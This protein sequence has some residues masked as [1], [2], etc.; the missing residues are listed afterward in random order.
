MSFRHTKAV[1][2]AR[3]TNSGLKLVALALAD[4]ANEAGECWPSRGHL[5]KL[6][7]LEPRSVQRHIQTLRRKGFLTIVERFVENRQRSNFYRLTGVTCMSGEGRHGCLPESPVEPSLSKESKETVPASQET[8]VVFSSTWKPDQRSKEAKLGAIKPP[9]NYPTERQFDDY[10]SEMA[11]DHVQTY[12]PDLYAEL[13]R[14]KWH[15]WR[16]DLGKWV[17]I[18]NWQDYVR[19]LDD[20]IATQ[21]DR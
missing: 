10:L 4:M 13:C 5:A 11:M 8:V 12:R 9:E 1:W 18:R 17:R 14:Q 3:F 6:C 21:F 15:Q 19:K 2:E 16:Q 7:E 20:T